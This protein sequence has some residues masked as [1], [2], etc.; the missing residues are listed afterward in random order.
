MLL[1][2]SKNCSHS[3]IY[4]LPVVFPRVFTGPGE[5]LGSYYFLVHTK[6]TLE[7][8]RTQMQKITIEFTQNPYTHALMLNNKIEFIKAVKN[9]TNCDLRSAK[10][11]AEK[12]AEMIVNL[13]PT[14]VTTRNNIERIISGHSE[15][16]DENLR[17]LLDVLRF[18]KVS[19]PKNLE[20]HGIEVPKYEHHSC[21]DE[22]RHKCEQ[23][24]CERMVSSHDEPYCFTHS[25]DSGSSVPG[26]DSRK[27]NIF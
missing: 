12:I 27:N 14:V 22:C 6:N 3:C 1:S 10:Q 13:K 23:S 19:Q 26:Y 11:T 2:T 18:M 25:P 5:P 15:N 17:F 8:R 20:N 4:H 7:H 16:T 9:A 21:G 24:S